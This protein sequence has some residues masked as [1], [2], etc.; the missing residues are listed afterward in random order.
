VATRPIFVPDAKQLVRAVDVPFTWHAGFAISQQQK[1]I[2]ALHEAGA[3]RGI[4]QILEISTK[5]SS[6]IG[7]RL[8]AFNLTLRL[9]SNE[10]VAV[11]CA[12]QAS[13]VFARGGP[14]LDLLRT[15]ASEAKADR[16]LRDSGNLVAFEFQGRRW[17][18]QP[19]SAFYVWLYLLALQNHP[20]LAERLLD[21][22][23]F[24]DIA[25][26]PEK[27][28]SNQAYAA[29]AYVALHRA[30]SLESVLAEPALLLQALSQGKTAV[31]V[32]DMPLFARLAPAIV[33]EKKL[34]RSREQLRMSA[35]QKS[36]K[37]AQMPR[38][39]NVANVRN[40]RGIITAVDE[41]DAKPEGRFHL[42]TVEYTDADGVADDRLIWEREPNA[43]V[44]PPSALPKV[45]T[46]PPMPPHEFDAMLRAARWSAMMPYVDPDAGGPLDRLPI[47]A[48]FHGAIQIEDFQLVPLL[49]ALR[50]PRIS[51]LV[52]DDVGL[53]KTIEAGLIL[54]E[55]LIRRRI[56]KV[57]VISPASL[58]KQWKQE[59][60]EKFSLDFDVVDRQRTHKLRQDYGLD[61]NP[62]RMFPRI[63]TSYYYLKQANVLEEFLS[64]SR[65][66]EGSP[67]L[68][69]DLL[70]VDEAHNLTPAPFG[71]DSDLAK[72]LQI[73]APYFEHK[74]FLTA[75]PHNGHT[76]SFSGLL[77][78]L[79]PVRFTRTS[80]Q[81]SE[82]EKTRIKDVVVRRLKS[83]INAVT[84]PPLFPNR[85]LEALELKLG[86]EEVALSAGA[87]QFR[88]KVRKL[89]AGKSRGEQ[90]A[91]AFAVEILSKR[92]LS[93]P[94]SFADSW[95]RYL[96]G[97][98][99]EITAD[100]TDVRAAESDIRAEIVSDEESEQRIAQ[101][102][103]TVGSW[104]KPLK[105]SVDEEVENVTTA[106]KSLG[107]K[108]DKP[109]LEAN[110]KRDARLDTV[111]TWIDKNLR[112]AN[113]WR[114]DERLVLFTEYKTTLDYVKRRLREKYKD[115][116]SAIRVL[117]GGMDNSDGEGTFEGIKAAFND[118]R[119]AVR[120]LV[121]TDAASE[122]LNLQQSARYLLHFDIP[123]NPARMEQRNGRID[124]HGQPRDVTIFHFTSDDDADLRFLS[125]VI[126]KVNA[127]R[128][129]L[130]S[131]AEVF[132]AAL[133]ERFIEGKEVKEVQLDLENREKNARGRAAVPRDK[134]A[135]TKELSG[136][137]EFRRLQA[138]RDELDLDAN[139]LRETLNVALGGNRLTQRPDG[140]WTLNMP[141]PGW[142][143]LID[144]H[145]RVEIGGS[146]AVPSLVFDPEQL[147]E[148][149]GPR[150][151]FRSRND[152]ALLHLGHPLLHRALTTFA[153]LRF[154][155][156]AGEAR[157][158]RWT[159]RY[160]DVPNGADALVL[161]SIE[162]LAVN[163]LRETFH[164]WVET[165][166]LI[167]KDGEMR[168]L[169]HSPAKVWRSDAVLAP[170]YESA[171]EAWDDIEVP[172]RQLLDSRR[173]ELTDQLQGVLSADGATAI[174]EERERFTS[175]QGEIS[176]L[177]QQNT[178]DRLE[179][180]IQDLD[181]EIRQGFIFDPDNR[182]AQLKATK[183]T[184]E[185]ELQR[186]K[187]QY[188]ELQKQLT[189]ERARVLDHLLP[190][191]YAMHAEA[192]VFPVA[193]EIRLPKGN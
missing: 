38:V 184:K 95:F 83:E 131:V 1:S 155:Q 154:S 52:A 50:M 67:H 78:A 190:K 22:R 176:K 111:T 181:A 87:D 9:A 98:T 117:Y 147:L 64:A 15:R 93:C 70:I 51:L 123:W 187:T 193:I 171:R 63:V 56:R 77:E 174:K 21:Y 185:D 180:E 152:T 192:Q 24:T 75:T 125:H 84:N 25:F 80:E 41:F 122:G 127:I 58:Q 33:D 104:L 132:D 173:T 61:A 96:R 97:A 189:S 28:V 175:R 39:G 113:G 179:R 143:T 186:R 81:F 53:G 138:L 43:E 136:E 57:L 116:G 157:A 162:E 144:D 118:P 35:Q 172:I 156:T 68:A 30:G 90:L 168:R 124:R 44:V 66:A 133:Q 49:K 166:P 182:L 94:A 170:K 76:R 27:S 26:N 106:L 42:V 165:L 129:D 2:Q 23:G 177:I 92:L 105:A 163:E 85:G 128:E 103:T 29:A 134:A 150:K 46:V 146:K 135:A 40:R 130:G 20:E 34:G 31:P 140:K 82:A 37:T 48:P 167:V 19:P 32:A 45:S 112:N 54:K 62:W 14:Y 145:L 159:V 5:S 142:E 16:R 18:L 10:H 121:A 137:E 161:L 7:R 17:P 164:H 100:A 11:E 91:G 88:K 158:T 89:I 141:V 191:R 6:D 114:A 115:E 102:A 71:E 13:K 126:G 3:K 148:Q 151:V 55:L 178:M 59:M 69:W 99:E 79:D 12:Y 4:D 72:M 101:A 60:D 110:P 119:S 86:P 108:S 160:G 120:I 183:A 139:T 65:P 153:R 73:I 169:E 149:V 47:S 8:S 107:F 109:P 36:G 74:I 188:I